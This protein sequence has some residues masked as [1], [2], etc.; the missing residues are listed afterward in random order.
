VALIPDAEF[1]YGPDAVNFDAQN[2]IDTA[3]GYLSTH[4]QYLMLNGWNTG[5]TILQRVAIENSVNPRLL[6]ALLEYQCGCVLGPE[7]PDGPFLGAADHIR[8]DLYGQLTWAVY[9]LSLGY[10]GWRAGTLTSFQLK[11]GSTVRIAPQ[12]DAGTAAIM[13][14]YGQLYGRAAWEQA[15][16]PET[17]FKATYQALF[18]DPYPDSTPPIPG[19]LQQPVL[20]LPFEKGTTWSYT[21]GP[22]PAFEGM[23]PWASLDFAPAAAESGC[24]PTTAQVLALSDG[25]V[26]RSEFGSIIQ[27]LDGDGLEQTGWNILYLHID[28]DDLP[29]AGTYLKAGD[30]VGRP[31]CEGGRANGTHVHLARKF[32]GEWIRAGSGP[33]PFNMDGWTAQEGASAYEGLLIRGEQI[34]SACTCSWAAG[35]LVVDE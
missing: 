8:A 1:V 11:D 9:H 17:G 2:F 22:H 29:E 35:W 30:P 25:L 21:G 15:I 16:D 32:N 34:R 5:F 19:N 10:Y 26:V 24:V 27:D 4:E 6:L 3:G 20:H 13:Y 31:S 7:P 18:G 33:L 12:T 23:G 14:L 28:P